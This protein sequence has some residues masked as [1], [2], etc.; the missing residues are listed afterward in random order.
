[1]CANVWNVVVK[2]FLSEILI[3]REKNCP[4]C[5]ADLDCYELWPIDAVEIYIIHDE[6]AT[7]DGNVGGIEIEPNEVE[8]IMSRETLKVVT[9]LFFYRATKTILS[10][11]GMPK[12]LVK[13]WFRTFDFF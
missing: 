5:R 9:H 11:M 6:E 10:V 7:G 1:M 3:F 13:K 12:K 4:L 2:N 8:T